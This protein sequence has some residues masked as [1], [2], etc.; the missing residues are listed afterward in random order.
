M[1]IN[2]FGR[3]SQILLRKYIFP[4]FESFSN[5]IILILANVLEL[6]P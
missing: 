2:L 6:F 3:E 4:R 1:E 5:G